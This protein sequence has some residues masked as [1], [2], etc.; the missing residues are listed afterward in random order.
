MTENKF[1]TELVMLPSKGTYYPESNPLSSGTVEV[2]YPRAREEDILTTQ[3]FIQRGI[4]IEKF[5][6]SII[7]NPDINLDDILIGDKNAIMVS[8]RILAYGKKYD[9]E[10]NCSACGELNKKT[11]DLTKIRDKKIN[12]DNNVKGTF[13]FEFKLPISENTITFKL[14][15]QKDDKN[16]RDTV[17]G[18][19]KNIKGD[20]VSSEVTTR[21]KHMIQSINGDKNQTIIN[22]F[23]DNMLSQDSLEFRAYYKSVMP[24]IDSTHLFECDLC[25]YEEDIT[26]PMTAQFF[27]PSSRV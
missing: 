21:Y 9:Y 18:L 20:I 11:T 7:V 17:K 15:T 24:D 4:V 1:P 25:G 22:D 10:L 27:W 3:N 13:E 26:V 16:I 2:R 19:Q 5:L 8:S 14:L 23:V 12:F 6:E